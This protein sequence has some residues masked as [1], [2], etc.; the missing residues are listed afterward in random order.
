LIDPALTRRREHCGW[1]GP[2]GAGPPLTAPPGRVA[3]WWRWAIRATGLHTGRPF[4]AATGARLTVAGVR[5]RR[6]TIDREPAVLSRFFVGG[7]HARRHPAAGGRADRGGHRPGRL[8]RS[9]G[10]R[11]GPAADGRVHDPASPEIDQTQYDSGEGPCLEA[12]DQRILGVDSTR[13]EGP[14]GTRASRVP[15]WV[16]P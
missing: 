11:R 1:P 3:W 8:R 13:G 7:G 10:A 14:T 15:G 16:S 6:L 2:T 4:L 5:H 9:D 12:V